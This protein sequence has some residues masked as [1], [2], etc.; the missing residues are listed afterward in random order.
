[1][2]SRNQRTD[3]TY[4]LAWK[5]A[6]TLGRYLPSHLDPLFFQQLQQYLSCPFGVSFAAA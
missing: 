1:M 4:G 5:P 3:R 2:A 6:P